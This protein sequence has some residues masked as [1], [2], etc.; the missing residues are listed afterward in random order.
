M[1]VKKNSEL[2]SSH[3]VEQENLSWMIDNLLT[4]WKIDT[5]YQVHVLISI[6][7]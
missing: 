1:I 4:T 7:N 6:V 5:Y 2:Q 3:N